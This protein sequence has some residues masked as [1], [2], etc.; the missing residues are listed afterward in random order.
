M[1][2]FYCSTGDGRRQFPRRRAR[3][4]KLTAFFTT[5]A[6]PSVKGRS[7]IVRGSTHKAP[8]ISEAAF[9]RPLR[10]EARKSMIT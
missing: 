10:Q 8:E 6:K 3:D 1:D 5:L 4:L 9:S 2:S 7:P